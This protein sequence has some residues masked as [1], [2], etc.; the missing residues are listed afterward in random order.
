MRG[1]LACRSSRCGQAHDEA[2][3]QDQRT[4]AVM[5]RHAAAILRPH[6]AAMR[7]DDLFG[8]RETKS[9]ILPEALMRPIGVEA[10][11]DFIERILAYAGPVIVDDDFDIALQ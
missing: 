4:R 5:R 2:R 3:A 8:D 7:F 11:E 9:G 6:A 1:C 10:L